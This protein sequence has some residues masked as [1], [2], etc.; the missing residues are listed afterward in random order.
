M[1]NY[2]EFHIKIFELIFLKISNNYFSLIS[3]P[4]IMKRNK[5]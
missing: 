1:F 5:R 3:K 4:A 2:T